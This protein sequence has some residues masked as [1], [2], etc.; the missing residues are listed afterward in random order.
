[1]T[2]CAKTYSPKLADLER[3]WLLVDADGLVLGRL[4]SII[5]RLLRGKHK[6]YYAPHLDC[7]DGVV[8]INAEKILLT[9]R[10]RG[11]KNYYRHTGYPGGLKTTKAEDILTGRF[12]DRVLCLAVKRM[13]PGG[14]LSRQQFS[15]LKVYAGAEHPHHAQS[16]QFLDIAARN[17][18]NTRSQ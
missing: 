13:L 16:P 18:K 3:K 5:A 10:K 14:P 17:R 8:V 9:G 2:I 4:A 7:G 1:M 12:P 6:P 11:Q 15:H